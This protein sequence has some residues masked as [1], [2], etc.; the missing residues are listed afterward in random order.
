VIY[1]NLTGVMQAWVAQGKVSFAV[2]VFATHSVVLAVAIWLF[3]RRVSLVR[4][5][6]RWRRRAAASPAAPAQP[7]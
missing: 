5:W 7:V 4:L 1:N 6:P 3:W 2:G